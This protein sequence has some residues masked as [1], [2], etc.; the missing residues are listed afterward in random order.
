MNWNT[1]YIK[2]KPGFETEVVASLANTTLD[3]MPGSLA[4]G[5]NTALFWVGEEISLREVK[6][7][8]G[9]KVVFKFRLKFFK[10]L[11]ELNTYEEEVRESSTS[12]LMIL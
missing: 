2:G 9:G 7:A 11:N 10:N 6:K 8:I 3:I 4:E 12:T 5:E 1:I